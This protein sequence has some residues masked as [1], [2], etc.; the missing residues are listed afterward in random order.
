[1]A[2]YNIEEIR[3]HLDETKPEA[4]SGRD[5]S[6]LPIATIRAMLADLE[7][8]D[9]LVDEVEHLN[10]HVAD[11]RMEVNAC[12]NENAALRK[13]LA[14]AEQRE[15]QARAIIDGVQEFI[16]LHAWDT[17]VGHRIHDFLTDQARAWLADRAEQRTA[18]EVE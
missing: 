5:F 8:H 4:W 12:T 6:R 18:Q 15:Q 9:D 2:T 11:L 16:V 17:S 13:R 7:D 14:A 1:M 3:R 10:Q